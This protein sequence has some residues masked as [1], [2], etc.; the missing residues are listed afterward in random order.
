[1]N[2]MIE[3]F[4]KNQV[5]KQ[6]AD[7][8][9]H[10]ARA[11]LERIKKVSIGPVGIDFSSPEKKDDLYKLLK[12]LIQ[13]DEDT[14]I[15]VDELP[16]FLGVLQN[17]QDG[18]EKVSNILNWLRSLRQVSGTKV[19]WLFCGS[20]GLKNFTAS[21]NLSYTINDLRDLRLDE[22]TPEEARGLLQLGLQAAQ[23]QRPCLIL[24]DHAYPGASPVV[25]QPL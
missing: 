13:H 7:D 14:F 2:L 18:K 6:I 3:H 21:L 9:F 24:Q 12:E 1:M 17:Q 11:I 25:S 10:G 8:V 19:R 20:V 22:L 16:W 23:V 5:W 4:E 15:V